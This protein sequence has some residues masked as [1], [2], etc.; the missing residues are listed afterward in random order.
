MKKKLFVFAAFMLFWFAPSLSM[1][2]DYWIIP[3]SFQPSSG[4]ILEAAFSNGHHYFEN[5]GV[6]DVT[7]FKMFVVAPDGKY[8]PL[9]YSRVESKAAWA[10]VPIQNQGTYV[11]GAVS[12][13]PE[14]WCQTSDGYKPGRKNEHPNAIKAGKYVKSVKTFITV[15]KSSESF[16]KVLGHEIEIMPQTNPSE[17]KADQTLS[18]VILFRGAPLA[19]VPVFGVYEGFQPKEHSDYPVQTKTDKNGAASIKVDQAGKWA[20]FA[21]HEKTMAD[22]NEVDFA[23]YRPYMMFEVK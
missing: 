9:A 15:G 2:H 13:M 11:I 7:K 19:D 12:T 4:T 18:V 21:K 20:V 14:Y 6:P 10:R 3:T 16:Q 5:E 17:L 22:G 1:A 8:V 23:N